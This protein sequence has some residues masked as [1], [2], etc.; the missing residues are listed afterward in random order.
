MATLKNKKITLDFVNDDDRERSI[1]I[2]ETTGEIKVV[3][4]SDGIVVEEFE[5][6]VFDLISMK[7]IDRYINIAD[8]F[9]DE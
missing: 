4:Y 8:Y 6:D 3:E 2:N 9:K 7:D 1:S 5:C